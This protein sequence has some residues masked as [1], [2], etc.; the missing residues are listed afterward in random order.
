MCGI[1][2][3]IALDGREVPGIERRLEVMS[4]L[5]EHRGPDD[6]GVWVHEDRHVGFAHRRLS[7]IDIEH[8][9]QPMTS[10]QGRW[11]TYNGELYNFPELRREIGADR[12]RTASDTEVVLRSFDRWGTD[13]LDRLRG[14]FAYAVWDEPLRRLVCVRDR[15]GI[16][17]LYYTVV[18]GVLH[19]ASEA[20]ALLPVLPSIEIDL[21]ALKDYLAFQF[22]LAGKTLFKGV[23]ELPP[24]H[25]LIA[26]DGGVH[27]HRYWEVY[28]DIDSNHT[29]KYF[30]EQISELLHESV[31]LHMR[32]DVPVAA[33][34]SGG[35]DSSVV[36]TL[37]SDHPGTPTRRCWRSPASSPN[38]P[39]MTRASTHVRS[40]RLAA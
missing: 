21:D 8:G 1:C 25:C 3:V 7:I 38:T 4:A 34:L 6:S 20:K 29:A 31:D 9:H 14:M 28:Y 35:L 36:A 18:D 23:H 24:G 33:Y 32:S 13:G 39:G 15:F 16:K 11:I 5:I 26:D 30:E 12:F 22:C 19:F 10:E 40:P 17:P 2:G 37:A 27:S